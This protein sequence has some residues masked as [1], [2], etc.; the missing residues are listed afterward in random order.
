MTRRQQHRFLVASTFGVLWIA[1]A[2]YTAL[3]AADHTAWERGVPAQMLM[4]PYTLA[5]SF[6]RPIRAA[7]GI[8][9]TILSLV[10]LW[11]VLT[12]SVWV[13]ME[14]AV[15]VRARSFHSPKR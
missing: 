12:V 7:F 5:R 2:V 15:N 10:V 14:L 8:P 1:V 6:G 11:I 9:G 4:L 13:L 3:E